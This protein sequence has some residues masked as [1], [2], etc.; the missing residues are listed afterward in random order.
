MTHDEIIEVIQAHRDDKQLQ[1]FKPECYWEDLG[2]P[3]CMSALLHRIGSGLS[4]RIKPEPTYVPWTADDWREF[5]G[6]A[7]RLE[8]TG[9]VRYNIKY[10]NIDSVVVVGMYND[11][12]NSHIASND[13]KY[14]YQTLFNKGIDC[15]SNKPCGKLVEK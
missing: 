1:L 8:N 6:K 12:Y 9:D 11:G 10:W 5:K 15:N 13:I 2:I 4:L 3:Y 14:S 7:F